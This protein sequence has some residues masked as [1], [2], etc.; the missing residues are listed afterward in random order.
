[1]WPWEHLAVGY[2]AYS[3][4]SRVRYDEPPGGAEALLLALG[5]QLPDLVDKP[6]AWTFGVLPSGTSVAH[7]VFVAAAFVPTV[8]LL[9]R[10]AGVPRWGTAL[11]FGHVS[12]LPG[13]VLYPLL[14]KGELPFSILL[15]PVV[16]GPT[17]EPQGFLFEF[18][19]L[20]AAFV[21]F[22]ATPRGQFY[23]GLELAL[24]L[25]ALVAWIVDGAPVLS[26]V[27]SAVRPRRASD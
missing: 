26:D 25:T 11:A 14:T 19:T 6:L 18:R 3:V 15:W 16:V 5:T 20:F 10:R 8:M 17:S 4:Y 24:L 21:E 2:V 22:L 13:D 12:H 23:L 7:S 27:V 9:A 1:M